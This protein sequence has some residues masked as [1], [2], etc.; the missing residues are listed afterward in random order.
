MSLLA[1]GAIA[2][3]AA[4][5]LAWVAMALAVRL[6]FLDRPGTEAH[7]RQTRAVPYGGGFAVALAVVAG[8]LA[9]GAPVP[10]QWPL[11]AG[12]AVLLAI[13]AWDDR[14]ALSARVKLGAQLI[15]ATA[16]VLAGGDHLRI[17]SLHQLLP[18]A[19]HVAAILWLVA[20]TN[21]Y[22][23]I[24]HADGISGTVGLISVGVLIAGCLL[25]GTPAALAAAG[26]WAALAGGLVGF[27][28]WNR[29]PA[30]IYLGDAGSMPLGFLIGGGALTVTF[31]PQAEHAGSPLALLAPL[32]VAAIPLFDS[33]V[34]VV[35]RWRR[36]RPIMKGDRNHI[37]HR[38]GR[39]G[40]SPWAAL[41]V[42]GALQAALAAGA[43]QLRSATLADAITTLVQALG[44][45]VAV[46]LLE[47]VRDDGDG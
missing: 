28:L 34:V 30:R 31:W 44:V 6:G 32:L 26:L 4:A 9:A 27:L 2:A 1:I 46:L 21:A 37:S 38:L 15:V 40:L 16:A 35:K 19:G 25:S 7:K 42:I 5:I 39:L 12:A 41:L 22:N 23:L 33:F 13:G 10:E 24:D 20:V 17:D 29:P 45:L 36:G 11:L 8:L 3:G 18:G 47:T 43:I 14:R